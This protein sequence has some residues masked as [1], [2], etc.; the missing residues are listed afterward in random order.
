M[1]LR[2]LLV[3]DEPDIVE[4]IRIGWKPMDLPWL[5]QERD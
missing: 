1:G 2:V 5:R 3:D 4:V